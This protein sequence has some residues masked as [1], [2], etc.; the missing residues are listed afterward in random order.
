M[1]MCYGWHYQPFIL[2]KQE[3]DSLPGAVEG[4]PSIEFIDGYVNRFVS[5]NQLDGHG[6]S[7]VEVSQGGIRVKLPGIQNFLC[8][9]NEMAPLPFLHLRP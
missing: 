3:F 4:L 9:V 2:A 5:A 7:V 1:V 8:K 6:I